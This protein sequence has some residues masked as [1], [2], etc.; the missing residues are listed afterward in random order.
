MYVPTTCVR[1]QYVRSC[2][3]RTCVLLDQRH[4]AHVV[5]VHHCMSDV[6]SLCDD[7]VPKMDSLTGYVGQTHKLG[8]CT[9]LADKILL[10]GLRKNGTGLYE[11]NC[12]SN[13]LLAT[14]LMHLLCSIN[15]RLHHNCTTFSVNY[16]SR[17]FVPASRGRQYL[18]WSLWSIGRLLLSDTLA[19]HSSPGIVSFR[20]VCTGTTWFLTL[21]LEDH[22]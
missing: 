15:V 20:C 22:L 16:G 4:A 6:G 9:R 3:Q 21:S 13:V 18:K 2:S 12:S 11:Y 19:S 14:V 17:A 7:Q 8:F 10:G 1:A 5:L